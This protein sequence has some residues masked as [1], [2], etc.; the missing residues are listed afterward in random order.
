MSGGSK[1]TPAKRHEEWLTPK[2]V[3]EQLGLTTRYLRDLEG[4]GLPSRGERQSKEYPWNR[5]LAWFIV[6]LKRREQT[7]RMP[8]YLDAEEAVFEHERMAAQ[9]AAWWRVKH[10]ELYEKQGTEPLRKAAKAYLDEARAK[11][12]AG[13]LPPLTVNTDPW[14]HYTR[15]TSASTGW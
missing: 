5:L 12:A 4:K 6:A 2:E 1:T 14:E 8:E 13:I 10:P 9:T 7:G 11:V 3:A 15:G